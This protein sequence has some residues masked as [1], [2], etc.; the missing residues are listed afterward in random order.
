[1]SSKMKSLKDMIMV[2]A[3]GFKQQPPRMISESIS[4]RDQIEVTK[5][6]TTNRPEDNLVNSK[7]MGDLLN[8]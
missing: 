1:M 5:V 7:V 8:Q 6:L 2:S 4:L 3:F